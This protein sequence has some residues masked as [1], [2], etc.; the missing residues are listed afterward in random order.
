MRQL[1]PATGQWLLGVCAMTEIV[2]EGFD[3]K[4]L[5]TSNQRLHWAPKAQRTAYWRG[6]GITSAARTTPRQHARI[7]FTLR[8]PD[9]RRRDANN[10]WPVAKA[11]V[12]GAVEVGLLPDDD[13]THLEGPDMRIDPC[14]GPHRIVV[15]IKEG[16]DD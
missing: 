11:W 12:D 1:R 3:P 6:L 9:R 16:G 7:I 15:S 4:M 8:F 2:L 14:P 5:L 10:W 13:S